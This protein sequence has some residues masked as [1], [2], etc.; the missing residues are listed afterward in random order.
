[1]RG[2]PLVEDMLVGLSLVFMYF[3]VGPRHSR[4]M[5]LLQVLTQSVTE[6]LLCCLI[7]VLGILKCLH[8]LYRT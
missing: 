2:R 7:G 4:P 1:M 3:G 5:Q 6:I 8:I